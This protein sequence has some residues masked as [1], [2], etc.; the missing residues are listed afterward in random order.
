MRRMRT[1]DSRTEPRRIDEPAAFI[2]DLGAI[3]HGVP[4]YVTPQN[5][6]VVQSSTQQLVIESNWFQCDMEMYSCVHLLL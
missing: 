2:F 3:R 4:C 5:S 1:C 6:W